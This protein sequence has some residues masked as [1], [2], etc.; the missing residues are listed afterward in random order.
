[1]FLIH[2]GRHEEAREPLKDHLSRFPDSSRGHFELGRVLLHAGRLDDA[3][4]HLQKAV[5]AD[6]Q[7]WAAHLLLGRVYVRLGRNVEGERHLLIGRQGA[8]ASE[9][10]R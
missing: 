2:Q 3:A 4:S 1:M 6:P 10:V 5:H 7:H 9:P 8:A